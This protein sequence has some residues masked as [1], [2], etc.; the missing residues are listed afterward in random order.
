MN[1]NKMMRAKQAAEYLG[2]GESTFWRWVH[3]GKIGKG[4]KFSTRCTVWRKSELDHFTNKMADA[5]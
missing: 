2:I 1:E 5:S 3:N 4:I